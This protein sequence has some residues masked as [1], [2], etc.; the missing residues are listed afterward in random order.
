[1]GLGLLLVVA[2]GALGNGLNAVANGHGHDSIGASTA[3]FGA[4]GI[5]AGM[6]LARRNRAGQ[7]G[8]RLLLPVGAGIGLLGMLGMGGVRVDVFAH[9]YGLLA[10]GLLGIG[11]SLA[12]PGRPPPR[13]QLALGLCAV[14]LVAICFALVLRA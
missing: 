3:V 8:A 9:L 13:I 11:A 5:L 14:A 2:S 4:I 7:S 12:A 6:A 1:V 10:G